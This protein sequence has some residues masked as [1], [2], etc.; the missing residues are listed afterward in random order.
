MKQ[1]LELFG[2]RILFSYLVWDPKG[3]KMD[4][5]THSDET[6]PSTVNQFQASIVNIVFIFPIAEIVEEIVDHD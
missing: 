1:V 2:F 5:S 3:T 4:I 6:L